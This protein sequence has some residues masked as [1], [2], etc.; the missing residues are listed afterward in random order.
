MVLMKYISAVSVFSH[1]F[2]LLSILSVFVY[3]E[4]TTDNNIF[5][6]NNVLTIKVLFCFHQ[7]TFLS[8]NFVSFI[9][10]QMKM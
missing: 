6:V 9:I 2:F 1:Q 4:F 5:M 8:L 7:R 10:T 3:T